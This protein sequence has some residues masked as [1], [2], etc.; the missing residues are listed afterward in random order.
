MEYQYRSP[1]EGSYGDGNEPKNASRYSPYT[2]ETHGES[3]GH[4]NIS[5]TSAG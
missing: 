1:L 5:Q 4:R 3:K 2:K